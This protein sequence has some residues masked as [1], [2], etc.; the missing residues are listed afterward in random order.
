MANKAEAPCKYNADKQVVFS[1][2]ANSASGVILDTL[3]QLGWAAHV[4]RRPAEPPTEAEAVEKVGA[5]VERSRGI[6][7][8][9][10]NLKLAAHPAAAR[11]LDLSCAEA[12][13]PREF[14][15]PPFQ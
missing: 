9:S 10:E 3:R 13:G 6:Q 2:Y 5:D 12:N 14:R 11:S 7:E 8:C 4:V 1:S 15:A